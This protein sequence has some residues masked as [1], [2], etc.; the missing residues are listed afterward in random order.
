MP[1]S[2]VDL[3]SWVYA[4]L[5]GDERGTSCRAHDSCSF[6]SLASE[7]IT[8]LIKHPR[9]LSYVE[10]LAAGGDQNMFLAHT[11]RQEQTAARAA[12]P[13]SPVRQ[14]PEG[15]IYDILRAFRLCGFTESR[16]TPSRAFSRRGSTYR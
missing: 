7:R 4:A 15:K 14:G 16:L 5:V 12:R 9:V 2:P 1:P 13:P 11:P 3:V 8:K 6:S 10:K